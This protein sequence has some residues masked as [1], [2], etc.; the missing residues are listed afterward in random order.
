[1]KKLYSVENRLVAFHIKNLLEVENIQC[2]VKNEFANGGV[3][4]LAPLDTW[5]E[6]WV[7]DHDLD[8]GEQA[9]VEILQNLDQISEEQINC[10]QCGESN[11][12][13]FKLCWNCEAN[14]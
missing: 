4:D 13:N 1:M 5:V 8:N 9:L 11:Q 14:L 7:C 10:P 3:G 2:Q 12:S 6:L